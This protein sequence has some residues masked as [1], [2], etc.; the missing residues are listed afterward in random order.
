MQFFEQHIHQKLVLLLKDLEN[1]QT[2]AN[3]FCSYNNID[4]RFNDFF[5]NNLREEFTEPFVWVEA[6][7]Y[8]YSIKALIENS[9]IDSDFHPTL[10][11]RNKNG[12]LI[13]M[14]K[15]KE[16]STV[17]N[18]EINPKTGNLSSI[19]YFVTQF[20]DLV[21]SISY[22]S[23]WSSRIWDDSDREVILDDS[24][25]PL[26]VPLKVLDFEMDKYV[27]NYIID[28]YDYADYFAGY[29][30]EYRYKKRKNWSQTSDVLNLPGKGDEESLVAE[31]SGYSFEF[32]R[33]E[34]NGAREETKTYSLNILDFLTLIG[35]NLN[36]DTLAPYLDNESPNWTEFLQPYSTD[37]AAVST[38][39]GDVIVENILK[40]NDSDLRRALRENFPPQGTIVAGTRQLGPISS[41]RELFQVAVATAE[42]FNS[43][44]GSEYTGDEY[45]SL[46]TIRQTL[47]LFK[48][49]VSLMADE[50]DYSIETDNRYDP[51][52]DSNDA[53]LGPIL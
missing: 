48:N 6:P 19:D 5:N 34:K 25:L 10:G 3:Q 8:F 52:S 40:V 41:V 38:T 29:A 13:D 50:I 24:F 27:S 32:S 30:N 31:I 43:T 21:S 33:K 37:S 39:Y 23:A 17:K 1:Y 51:N 47:L 22:D 44:G 9:W 18:A 7:K 11:I 26:K 12:D 49:L 28:E 53:D 16:L 4:N 14:E 2:L 15:I 42:S 45:K 20:A 35:D 46:K 36:D